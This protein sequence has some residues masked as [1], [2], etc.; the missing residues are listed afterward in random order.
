MTEVRT[1][2]RKAP[3]RQV[4]GN[5]GMWLFWG[6]VLRGCLCPCG[7]EDL[8]A[9]ITLLQCALWVPLPTK[10]PLCILGWGAGP[11]PCEV[12]TP[13]YLSI[14]AQE[15]VRSLAGNLIY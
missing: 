5:A 4:R 11:V 15:A 14:P 3:D 12:R 6:L 9:L 1:L 13:R 10:V 2:K 8:P 7:G